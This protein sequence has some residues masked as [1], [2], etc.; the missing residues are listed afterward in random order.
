M[1]TTVSMPLSSPPLSSNVTVVM[2]PPSPPSSFVQTRRAFGITSMYRPKNSIGCSKDA[3]PNTKRYLPPVRASMSQEMNVIPHDFGTHHR[4]SSSGVA[5]ASNT[6]H[7]GA[8]KVRVMTSSRS[9][10]GSTVVRFSA[11]EV[12]LAVLTSIALLPLLQF[13]NNLVQR[14]EARDQELAVSLQPCRLFLQPA[15]AEPAGPHAP[16]LLRGDEPHLFQD[17]DMLLHAREGHVEF[18]GKLRDRRVRT[19]ELLQDAAPC[20]VRERGEGGI[21]A[22]LAI[23]NHLVQYTRGLAGRKRGRR[24]A[25]PRSHQQV[26]QSPI[27]SRHGE[28]GANHRTPTVRII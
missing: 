26:A 20:G 16:D 28:H 2:A 17:A 11:V 23:M 19:P 18:L 9:D 25:A 24:H 3:W 10:F 7:A 4:L 22:V 12:S 13:L 8:W 21:E 5:Q 14:V 27:F 15:R 6:R 1:T